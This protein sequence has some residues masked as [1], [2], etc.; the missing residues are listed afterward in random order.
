[1]Q[2]QL[3]LVLTMLLL[4]QQQAIVHRKQELA[5]ITVK[6]TPNISGNAKTD[7]TNCNTATGTITLSGLIPGTLYY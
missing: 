2:Q 7:P 5:A 6:P 3:L 1:M 4:Q